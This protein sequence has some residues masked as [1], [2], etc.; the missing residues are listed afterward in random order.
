MRSRTISAFA[1][2][3]A[4]TRL[5]AQGPT[6]PA[7]QTE[8]DAYTR[9]ELLAPG[10]A[11]FRILYEVTATTPAAR[12][13]FN[14]IR[15]GS[16][17]SDERVVDRMTG[18]PLEFDIVDGAVARAAGVRG[19]DTTGQ[20]IRVRLAR[21]VPADGE[22]RI[23]IDKTY[24]DP[25]SYYEQNGSLVFSRPLGIK[26]NSVVLP[27]GYELVSCNYPSQVI[28]EPDGRVKIAFWNNTPAEAP[29]TIRARRLP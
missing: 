11:K 19:A 8:T 6:S 9:Y 14:P 28:T 25:Q 17:A 3:F 29:L 13:Y 16:V 5:G 21:P 15:K 24:F 22:A 10:S 12:Y 18:A 27:A 7:P 23:L 26:R 20:Y 1:L 4:A 2:A